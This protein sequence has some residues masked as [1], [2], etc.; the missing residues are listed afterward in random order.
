[1]SDEAALSMNA[2]IS[3][4][5]TAEELWAVCGA[6]G[7]KAER[8]QALADSAPSSDSRLVAD[9]AAVT[10]GEK[11]LAVTRYMQERARN[12][13]R[14]LRALRR[15]V[16]TT[17]PGEFFIDSTVMYPLMRAALEDTAALLWLQSPEGRPERLT[18][19]FRTLVS[20][21]VFYTENNRLLGVAVSGVPEAAGDSEKLT[22]H[23]EEQKRESE[24]HFRQ[25]AEA[26][27]LDASQALKK[28]FTST[29]VQA[30]YG[31]E[32]VEFITWKF[33][34]DLSHFSFMML[35]HLATSRVPESD[36]H[37]EHVTLLQ[38]SQT[39]NRVCDD[40][41]EAFERSLQPT[42]A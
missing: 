21:N 15:L 23:M 2:H 36:A 20:E 29:P 4:A 12:A 1:M 24:E 13:A 18:R 3:Q 30:E 41:V 32:S 11:S 10:V 27:G 19:I 25:L 26:V 22:A 39:V 5:E 17:R 37:L 9:N 7:E 42:N 38:F 6:W 33:L 34:S 35:R 40:A 31:S 14:M 8:L 28:T 16:F